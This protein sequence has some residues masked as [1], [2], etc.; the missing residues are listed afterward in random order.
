[1][2]VFQRSKELEHRKA[3]VGQR[4]GLRILD[5]E[6][7]HHVAFLI[8]NTEAPSLLCVDNESSSQGRRLRNTPSYK[9]PAS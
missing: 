5:A 2:K 6:C 7:H 3:K 8:V 9:I 4:T 1:M